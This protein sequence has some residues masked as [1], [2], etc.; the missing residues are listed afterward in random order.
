MYAFLKLGFY[1]ET[2]KT[3]GSATVKLALNLSVLSTF[4]FFSTLTYLRFSDL[5]CNESDYTYLKVYCKIQ[6]VK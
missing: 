2:F 3:T 5:F 4:K 6:R 1:S